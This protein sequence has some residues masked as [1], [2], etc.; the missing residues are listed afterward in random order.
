MSKNAS[1]VGHNASLVGHVDMKNKLFK[2]RTT[3]TFVAAFNILQNS[4]IFLNS[5]CTFQLEKVC[6]RGT[7]V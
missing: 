1:F 6:T 4:N 3:D 2:C 5:V 7:T